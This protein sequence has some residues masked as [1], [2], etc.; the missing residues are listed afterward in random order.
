MISSDVMAD[1]LCGTIYAGRSARRVALEMCM[2]FVLYRTS[3]P[4]A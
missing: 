4:S 2:V 3:M 1:N